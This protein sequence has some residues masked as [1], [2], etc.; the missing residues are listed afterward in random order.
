MNRSITQCASSCQ[1]VGSY[2]WTHLT[3][4]KETDDH[5]KQEIREIIEDEQLK[6]EFNLDARKFSRNY[7]GSMF[8][9]SLNA[10]AKVTR[11]PFACCS[12]QFLSSIY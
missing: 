10:G 12:D 3:N 8:F 5:F 11:Y 6:K 1:Q 4:L 9:D 2:V 7:E